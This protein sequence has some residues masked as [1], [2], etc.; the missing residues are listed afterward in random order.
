MCFASM[1]CLRQLWF[2]RIRPSL[3]VRTS[4]WLSKITQLCLNFEPFTWIFILWMASWSNKDLIFSMQVVVNWAVVVSE[5]VGFQSTPVT[6]DTASDLSTLRPSLSA[7]HWACFSLWLFRLWLGAGTRNASASPVSESAVGWGRQSRAATGWW[8]LQT[9]DRRRPRR[10]RSAAGR[11]S[12]RPST[13][14][15]EL[16]CRWRSLGLLRSERGFA[17]SRSSDP[18]WRRRRWCRW[19]VATTASLTWVAPTRPG[20]RRERVLPVSAAT[21]R[22]R[23]QPAAQGAPR[24]PHLLRVRLG[25][26]RGPRRRR[27]R[28]APDR[29]VCAPA[30]RARQHQEPHQQ[31]CVVATH[32][33][34]AA[35]YLPITSSRLHSFL[36]WSSP[37]S[38]FA[39]NFGSSALDLNV[40]YVYSCC[41]S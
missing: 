2:F 23:L 27:A 7:W 11:R 37:V 34:R 39:A 12:R 22:R 8:L 15:G 14:R 35:P 30:C 36:C 4:P 26:R 3:A 29:R 1:L 32:A 40:F 24:G 28:L 38:P 5:I 10:R 16:H 21:A 19:A 41:V 18:T 6:R 20:R 9:G 31:H 25:A 13:R 17:G 33:N